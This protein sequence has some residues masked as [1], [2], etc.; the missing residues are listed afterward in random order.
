MTDNTP[1][2]TLPYIMAAQAQKHVTHNEAL[3]MLDDIV[4]LSVLDRDLIAPPGAPTDGDRYIVAAGAAGVWSGKDGQIA[5]WQDNGWAYFPPNQGWLVWVMDEGKVFAWDG[6]AWII[7]GGDQINPAPLVGVNTM[8]DAS[9]R[10]AI[11]SPNSLFSHEGN[12]HQLKVNKNT[13]GDTASVLFQS[14][15]SG[16]A[17]F[18][19]T[20]DDNWHVKVSPDG[21]AWNE[22]LIADKDTGAVRF[23]AGLEHDASRQKINSLIMTPGGAG[24]NSIWRFDLAR[25]GIPRQATILSVSGDII[26]LTAAVANQFFTNSQM[27]NVSYVRIWNMSKN[28]EQSAWVK[29]IAD[30]GTNTQLQVLNAA[31]ISGWANGETVQ[32]GEPASQIPTNVVAVDIS[33]MMQNMLGAIF[34]QAGLLVKATLSA[35]AVAGNLGVTPTGASGSFTNIFGQSDGSITSGQITVPSTVLSPIS[36]SNLLFIRETDGG[37]DTLLVGAVSVFGIWV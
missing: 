26:T 5:A 4:Q 17:E 1:N 16:R 29:R 11:S 6:T 37:A 28:P 10:L 33:P 19:L 20:G 18:G 22:A 35:D 12:G 21:S 24:E 36:N 14:N 31:D 32:L 27:E 8:A 3:R 25:S 34:P 13:V 2:L 9:N 15:W 30:V 23:P 7:A